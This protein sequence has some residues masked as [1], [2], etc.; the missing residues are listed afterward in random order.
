MYFIFDIDSL[1]NTVK[2]SQYWA[3][4]RLDSYSTLSYNTKLEITETKLHFNDGGIW[5]WYKFKYDDDSN[6]TEVLN[7][8]DSTYTK[9]SFDKNGNV[10]KS[11]EF[12]KYGLETGKINSYIYKYD[13]KSNWT[14]RTQ[15][16]EQGDI[17]CIDER[18][19]QYYKKP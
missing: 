17:V 11:V 5:L 13:E 4:G 9:N 16:N 12:D 8:D 10:V 6:M 3:D 7:C 15:L 2:S 19:Y 1:G 18:K 14:K